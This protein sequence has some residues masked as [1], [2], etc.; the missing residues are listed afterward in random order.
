[1]NLSSNAMKVLQSRYLLESETSWED[2]TKRVTK[3]IS[4]NEKENDIWCERFFDIVNHGQF[5]PGGR[6]L[7]NAGRIKGQLGNCL[8]KDSK[9][10]TECGLVELQNLSINDKVL[11]HTGAFSSVAAIMNKGYRETLLE[12]ACK[13]M[14]RSTIVGTPDHKLLVFN[15]TKGLHWKELKELSTDDTVAIPFGIKTMLKYDIQVKDYADLNNHI[16]KNRNGE[17]LQ[18]ITIDNWIKLKNNHPGRWHKNGK[19]GEFNKQISPV[20]NNI[21]LTPD[22]FRLVGYFLA[23]GTSIYNGKAII[24]SLHENEKTLAKEII[25]LIDKFFGVKAKVRNNTGKSI[26]VIANSRIL[27][28]FFRSFCG[29]KCKTKFIPWIVFSQPIECRQELIR[30]IMVGDGYIKKS[31]TGCSI[32][33]ANEFLIEQL[34]LLSLS[35]GLFPRKRYQKAKTNYSNNCDVYTLDF[36]LVNPTNSIK[37]AA[38][39]KNLNCPEN[40]AFYPVSSITE[41]QYNDDVF[42]ISVAHDHSFYTKGYIAHNCFCLPLEDS[43]ESI[44]EFIKNALI[45]WSYGGGLGMKLN[46]RPKGAPIMGKGGVS[47]GLL[48]YLVAIDAVAHTIESGGQRRAACLGICP[49]SHPE[50]LD[51]IDAKLNQHILPHFNLSVAI[52][53]EFLEAVE[54]GNSWKFCFGNR[55]YGSM[56]AEK[57]WEKIVKNMINSGEPGIINWGNFSKNNSYYFA[58]V[59]AG[60]ACSEI[61]LEDYGIC[62]SKNTKIFAPNGIREVKYPGEIIHT[63]DGLFEKRSLVTRKKNNGIRDIYEIKL[64]GGRSIKATGNHEMM[65]E[66]GEWMKVEDLTDGNAL[67]TQRKLPCIPF[68]LTGT[69]HEMYGWQHGNGWFTDTKR[70]AL[71]ISFSAK[72]GDFDLKDKYLKIFHSIFG[73]RI[74]LKNDSISYQEQTC[75]QSAIKKAEDLG[76]YKGKAENKRLPRFFYSWDLNEQLSFMRGLFNADSGVFGKSNKMIQLASISR[77]LLDEVQEFLSVFGIHSSASIW[78]FKPEHN[79]KPQSKLIISKES[80]IKY[81]KLIGFSHP[82]KADKFNWSYWNQYKDHEHIEI[83][84]IK[85]CGKDEVWDL[86]VPETQCFFANGILVHNCNIGSLVLPRFIKGT[87]TDWKGLE[88]VIRI[89]IRYL[90]NVIDINHYLLPEIEV[91]AKNARRLGLGT[92]GLSDYLFSKQIIYGSPKAITEIERLY[93]FIRDI[94]YHESMMLA[95]E[96]GAFPKFDKVDY[97]KASF[98]RKLP[99]SLRLDIKKY[100]IR[101]C[102]LQAIAPTGTTSL[103]ADVNSGIEPLFSK[104]YLRKD[105][106]GERYYIHPIYL[107]CLLDQKPIPEWFVDTH[108]I[109]PESHFETQIAIGK[110]IDSSISKTI[111]CPKDTTAEDLSR[112]LLEYIWDMKSVT[113]YRDGSRKKQILYPLAEKETMKVIKEK[114]IEKEFLEEITCEGGVCEIN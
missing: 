59:S 71:G 93:K 90:D 105:N 95:Q 100:G 5:I 2:V 8:R 114:R 92:M 108:D 72:D 35:I 18:F 106:V 57:L 79:R 3:A 54:R 30:G 40:Y 53:Q 10:L 66:S 84:S 38:S 6:Q 1:M 69:T 80:A 99:H 9:V 91:A 94:S 70:P 31:F 28:S 4:Q 86:E 44:G 104:A 87:Q 97:G 88:N 60:N 37:L 39:I 15:L 49:I 96:K 48:S 51:Y 50:V 75:K 76:F 64:V 65:S 34:F 101:N 33:L 25:K 17:C 47:S 36:S 78:V 23:E 29:D 19:V 42:D 16:Y 111:N 22:F 45:L 77:K 112:L 63:H 24:F 32:S 110:Y 55:E 56:S 113:I 14:P 41:I 13:Y 68:Q 43:S 103:I 82:R 21:A 74:P 26:Q 52:N 27:N 67:L 12:V 11:T 102:T 73:K 61:P 83:E 109:T 7:R 20:K 98:V 81:M 85:H 62:L 46:L 89:A 58:K 107:E